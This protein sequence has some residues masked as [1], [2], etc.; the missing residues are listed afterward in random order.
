MSIVQKKTKKV[1]MLQEKFTKKSRVFGNEKKVQLQ[2]VRRNDPPKE[3]E[4]KNEGKRVRNEKR[5]SIIIGFFGDIPQK[6][7]RKSNDFFFFLF[8]Q[9][10][11]L[12]LFLE[13]QKY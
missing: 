4:A 7:G 12:D 8:P 5:F 2:I 3:M 11:W 13:S 1:V 9:L 10:C 6:K